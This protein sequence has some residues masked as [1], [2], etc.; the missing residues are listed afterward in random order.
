[1][2]ARTAKDRVDFIVTDNE[3]GEEEERV[4]ILIGGVR[5]TVMSLPG[6]LRSS[7]YR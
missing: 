4:L 1:M 6:I 5:M 7:L 3:S 2:T